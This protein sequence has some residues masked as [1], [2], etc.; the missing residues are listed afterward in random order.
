MKWSFLLLA[1]MKD[2]NIHLV[3][4]ERAE[5]KLRTNHETPHR[6]HLPYSWVGHVG[7]S[8]RK[9]VTVLMLMPY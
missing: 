8:S 2:G 4:D 9:L 6:L 7:Q 3:C 5:G 1:R